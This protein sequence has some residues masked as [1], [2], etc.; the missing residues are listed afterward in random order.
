MQPWSQIALFDPT[1]RLG[2]VTDVRPF[3]CFLDVEASGFGP[4]SYPIE[5]AWNLPDG[6]IT[7]CL[8][9]PE[10]VP[11]WTHWDAQA[12]QVHGI[13]RDRLLRNGWSPSYV[14]G[15]LAADL[16]GRVVYTDAPAF[17]AAWLDRLFSAVDRPLPFT[18]EHSDE[19]LLSVL[20]T[21]EGAV[22]EAILR[23]DALKDELRDVR[24][25][26]HSAGYDV[27]YLLSL[28]RHAHGEPIKMHHGIGPLPLTTATGTF[29][30]MKGVRMKG[31]TP[32]VPSPET[33]RQ[34]EGS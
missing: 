24:S 28:W 16:G 11:T 8:I 10:D 15:R 23:L 9:S 14:A 2:R 22:W 25:G 6:E 4:D 19:L 30:R 7:R 27:G 29:L 20:R 13:E 18:I 34:V 17:D 33:P 1:F 3:P 21:A 32:P 26:K 12:E 31:L 5:V